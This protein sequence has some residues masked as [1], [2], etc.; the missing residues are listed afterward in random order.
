MNTKLL[1]AVVASLSVAQARSVVGPA[2]AVAQRLV[3]AARTKT[4]AARVGA[5]TAKRVVTQKVAENPKRTVATMAG[6]A[7]GYCAAGD[8][9]TQKTAGTLGGAALGFTLGNQNSRLKDVQ[10]RV[11]DIQGRVKG[12]DETVARKTDLTATEAALK[13]HTKDLHDSLAKTTENGFAKTRQALK[14]G[15]DRLSAQIQEGF[16][17]NR[18]FHSRAHD[19]L[20]GLWSR[21][22]Q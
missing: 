2:R 1:L 12:L 19:K 6:G 20:K 15:E 21:W 10:S 8:S 13:A 5:Q 9:W 16:E 22:G 4:H 11:K 7:T 3:M 18:G 17:Q 14:N